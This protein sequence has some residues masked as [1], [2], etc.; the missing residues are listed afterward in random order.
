MTAIFEDRKD[1][2]RQLAKKLSSYCDE[3]T[4]VLGMP[5]GG[6]VVAAEVARELKL[7]L[8]VIVARKIGAPGQPE[9]AIGAI[10]GKDIEVLNEDM[11]H[12]FSQ[13]EIQEIIKR[14]RKEMSR[15]V[16]LYTGGSQLPDIEGRTVI[17]VDDGIATGLTALATVKAVKK[18]KP[19]RLIL[20]AG[21]CAADSVEHLKK[22]V[23]DVICVA[24]PKSF[25]AVGM[26]YKHFDQTT[27]EE[28]MQALKNYRE[29]DAD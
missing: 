19:K 29:F 27:D 18:M 16:R 7:P 22:E 14:E 15:R 2:G 25:Y 13:A 20:A 28:V 21:V 24:S 26:W 8:D 4:L 6:V 9:F 11:I 12:H 23:D 3:N 10:S 5:R 17:V 1:A